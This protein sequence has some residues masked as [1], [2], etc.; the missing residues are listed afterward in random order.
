MKISY[1]IEKHEQLGKYVIWKEVQIG[2][3]ICARGIFQGT[4]KQC[5]EKLENI[6]LI[7]KGVEIDKYDK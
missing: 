1:K 2:N 4:R 5:E 3:G 6:K 7:L